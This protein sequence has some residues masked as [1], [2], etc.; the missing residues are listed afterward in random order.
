[1]DTINFLLITISDR[2]RQKYR[3]VF[4]L[5]CDICAFCVGNDIL[6]C[7]DTIVGNREYENKKLT[8]LYSD[9]KIQK[10]TLISYCTKQL[11]DI[12]KYFEYIEK[13]I[14]SLK[15]RVKRCSHAII[16]KKLNKYEIFNWWTGTG[17]CL[18]LKN[19]F[20]L[21]FENNNFVKLSPRLNSTNFFSFESTDQLISI[22]LLESDWVSEDDKSKMTIYVG[23]GKY[24]SLSVSDPDLEGL[25]KQEIYKIIS[26]VESI[27]DYNSSHLDFLTKL[28]NRLAEF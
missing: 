17:I 15:D 24:V 1:M 10:I 9:V 7:C 21:K 8:D 6:Y 19:S 5:K 3:N 22:L 16:N 2:I 13:T 12:K 20:N 4:E 25:T 18:L 28:C 11:N 14:P 26:Y 27:S 23:L